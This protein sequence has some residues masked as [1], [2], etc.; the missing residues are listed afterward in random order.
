MTS[1][2]LLFGALADDTR[3]AFLAQIGTGELPLSRLEP[4]RSMSLAGVIKHVR[5]LEEAGLL[6]R[7]KRGRTVW[8]RSEPAPLREAAN[9]IET[10]Q[11]FWNERLDALA[12]HLTI[13]GEADRA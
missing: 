5:V 10:Y 8:C 9:W 11:G 3:R 4:P 1:L 2:D 13:N 7:E 6:T 12:I